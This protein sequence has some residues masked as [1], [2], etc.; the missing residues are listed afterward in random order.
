MHSF[1]CDVCQSPA[2][3]K[4]VLAL[5]QTAQKATLAIS[6]CSFTVPPKSNFPSS[7]HPQRVASAA[8]LTAS[9]SADVHARA[10]CK[11]GICLHAEEFLQPLVNKRRAIV[12]AS[13]SK[14]PSPSIYPWQLI[15]MSA[16]SL[17]DV[18][19]FVSELHPRMQL[20]LLSPQRPSEL[21]P[22]QR[23]MSTLILQSVPGTALWPLHLCA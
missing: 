20:A 21:P 10:A 3:A 7:R 9:A 8:A 23:S 14:V 4:E 5:T 2:V 1:Y 13:E 11:H 12:R 17:P 22:Q 19:L 15:A 16:T 6:R 18:P